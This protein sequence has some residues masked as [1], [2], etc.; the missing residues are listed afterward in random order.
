MFYITIESFLK[1][2]VRLAGLNGIVVGD[3]WTYF[4]WVAYQYYLQEVFMCFWEQCPLIDTADVKRC[5]S[6]ESCFPSRLIQCALPYTVWAFPDRNTRLVWGKCSLFLMANSWAICCRV[7][8]VE[9][10]FSFNRSDSLEI[11]P[12]LTAM[13]HFMSFLAQ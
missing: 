9:F 4:R 12:Q 1:H 7:H 13:Q 10:F 2:L 11:P 6:V 3:E 5:N 8:M